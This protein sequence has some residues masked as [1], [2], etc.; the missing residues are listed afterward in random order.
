MHQIVRLGNVNPS[1]R[2]MNGEVYSIEGK[3]PTVTTNKGEGSKISTRC[4]QVQG[5]ADL[6]GHDYI[7]RVYSPEG[8]APTLNANGGGN[9]EPKVAIMQTPRGKNKGGLKALNGKTPSMTANSWQ[10]NNKLIKGKD[11]RKLTPIECERLQ[12]LPDNYTL[13]PHPKFKN[14]GMSNSQRYKMLG[15][16]WTVE[17]IKHIYKNLSTL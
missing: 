14:R 5:E 1:G 3:S 12:T 16:G 4:I 9:L 15:N 11:W 8:K 7:K 10:D 13:C 2:G 17:V 6:K